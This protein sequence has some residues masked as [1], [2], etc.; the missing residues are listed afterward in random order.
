MTDKAAVCPFS[1]LNR[2]NSI[3]RPFEHGSYKLGLRKFL[4]T[5]MPIC[6]P[7]VD[8]NYFYQQHFEEAGEIIKD[9]VADVR[10]HNVTIPE[11]DKGMEFLGDVMSARFNVPT[12]V[13]ISLSRPVA[14][15]VEGD[16]LIYTL[17][18]SVPSKPEYS[19]KTYAMV[20][21]RE[22]N[23]GALLEVLPD[24]RDRSINDPAY[25]LMSKQIERLSG[26][27]DFSMD[28]VVRRL[29]E[30]G[31]ARGWYRVDRNGNQLLFIAKLKLV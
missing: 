26:N 14:E 17:N 11:M 30:E 31:L 22:L 8:A 4:E 13:S 29:I 20:E 28:Y 6:T 2:F 16:V 18:I 21:K 1:D 24:I 15:I 25:L 3:L 23:L 27:G 5:Y 19:T 10:Y 12:T 9:R 7:D